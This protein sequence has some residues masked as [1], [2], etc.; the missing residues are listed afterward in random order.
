[1]DFLGLIVT[2]VVTQSEKVEVVSL[3]ILCHLLMK[4]LIGHEHV[5]PNVGGSSLLTLW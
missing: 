5:T 3:S 4:R 2:P 1:M